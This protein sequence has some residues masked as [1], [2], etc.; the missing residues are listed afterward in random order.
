MI[1][2][3]PKSLRFPGLQKDGGAGGYNGT[4]SPSFQLISESADGASLCVFQDSI[5]TT[6]TH[7]Q[8]RT[9][10]ATRIC[11]ERGHVGWD[12]NRRARG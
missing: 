2:V 12:C 4:P 3:S 6:A 11:V 1:R 8:N 9:I 10:L 7:I 5:D